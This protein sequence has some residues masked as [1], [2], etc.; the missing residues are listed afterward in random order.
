MH[1]ISTPK[2]GAATPL[3][4]RIVPFY[5]AFLVIHLECLP[6]SELWFKDRSCIYAGGKKYDPYYLASSERTLEEVSSGIARCRTERV[7]QPTSFNGA[8]FASGV[9]ETIIA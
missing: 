7:S 3:L 9:I 6:M 1:K 5:K 2:R 8:L 4:M